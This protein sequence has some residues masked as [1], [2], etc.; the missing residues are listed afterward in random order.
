M[1]VL[2][3]YLDK[4]RNLN[5]ND[6]IGRSDSYIKFHLKKDNVLFDKGYGDQVSS[7][8]PDDN[9]PEY[10]ETFTFEDVPSLESMVLHVQVVDDDFIEFDGIFP[11]CKIDLEKLNPSA[12]GSS[13][14]TVIDDIVIRRDAIIFLTISYA[15]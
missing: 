13:I 2:T 15:E 14:E 6:G 7:K 5:D 12:D 9:N 10:G 8:K 1:G 3:V 11:S 4:I